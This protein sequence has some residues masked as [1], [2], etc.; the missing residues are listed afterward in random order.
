MGVPW[1]SLFSN[2]DEGLIL[3]KN[4]HFAVTL[5]SVSFTSFGGVCCCLGN[6]PRAS[7]ALGKAPY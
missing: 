6:K 2:N 4:N 1:D 3:Y 5:S 7:Q